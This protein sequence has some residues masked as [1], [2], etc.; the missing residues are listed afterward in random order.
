MLTIRNDEAHLEEPQGRRR[1]WAGR[2]AAPCAA[3]WAA[4]R[5]SLDCARASRRPSSASSRVD[6][7]LRVEAEVLD[8]RAAEHAHRQRHHRP[9]AV[10]R[11]EPLDVAVEE[12]VVG[13]IDIDDLLAP[14]GSKSLSL[15]EAG[16]R[17][18]DRRRAS[19]AASDANRRARRVVGHREAD[20]AV[21]RRQRRERESMAVQQ[22]LRSSSF[23]HRPAGDARG[24]C[25]RCREDA[26]VVQ[27]RTGDATARWRTRRRRHRR[28]PRTR[29][30]RSPPP[31]PSAARPPL[32]RVAHGGG[33]EDDGGRGGGVSKLLHRK[34]DVLVHY[35]RTPSIC[36]P[37]ADADEALPLG[38][39]SR[40][41][42]P[43]ATDIGAIFSPP[44]RDPGST[45]SSSRSSASSSSISISPTTTS[46]KGQVRG[47]KASA[48]GPVRSWRCAEEVAARSSTAPIDLDAEF[49]FVYSGRRGMHVEE[50]CDSRARAVSNEVRAAAPPP[51]APSAVAPPP[52]PAA[53]AAAAPA[54]PSLRRGRPPRS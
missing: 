40:R 15:S 38:P 19:T 49:L 39:P 33:D 52:P 37:D 12:V 25:S 45:S 13:E 53:A 11:L 22:V 1:R 44:P 51:P 36:A 54:A 7:E 10:A 27:Q 28:R 3:A 14:A 2:V 50:V 23:L 48:E 47:Q 42:L 34:Q 29:A 4:A 8:E 43:F 30:C 17:R 35:A 32:L 26:V 46:E 21:R 6:E 9:A 31:S 20:V 16:L 5:T 18:E 24:T 41:S